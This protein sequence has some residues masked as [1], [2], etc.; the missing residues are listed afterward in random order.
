MEIHPFSV[1]NKCQRSIVN[2]FTDR[3]GDLETLT[4][5]IIVIGVIVAVL[6]VVVIFPKVKN[7]CKNKDLRCLGYL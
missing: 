4:S 6:V 3:H 5:I 2:Y 1:Y 7:W